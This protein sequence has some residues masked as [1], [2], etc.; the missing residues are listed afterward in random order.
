MT[1]A[2]ATQISLFSSLNLDIDIVAP[3]V[4]TQKVP[5]KR[6][7]RSKK[8]ETLQQS[9]EAYKALVELR[10]AEIAKLHR[11]IAFVMAM[12]D[13]QQ[14][15]IQFLKPLADTAIEAKNSIGILRNTEMFLRDAKEELANSERKNRNLQSTI[16]RRNKKIDEVSLAVAVEKN[17]AASWRRKYFTVSQQLR[18]IQGS[19]VA[20]AS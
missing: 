20:A 4:K 17:E 8:E 3:K 11:R 18:T 9:L 6:S 5:R 7:K 15:Q 16:Y 13:D 10:D 1:T 2:T 19:D 14:K 12:Y